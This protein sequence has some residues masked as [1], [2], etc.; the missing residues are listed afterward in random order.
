MVL[1]FF[2]RDA[3]TVD[4]TNHGYEQNERF[5]VFPL[6]IKWA[7][8]VGTRV[9]STVPSSGTQRVYLA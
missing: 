8:Q 5:F 3:F 7:G 4:W 9:L 1:Q 6:A 2:A